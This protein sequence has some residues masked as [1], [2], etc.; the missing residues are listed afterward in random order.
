M[1][2]FFISCVSLAVA[3]LAALRP[4]TNLA[5]PPADSANTAARNADYIVAIVNSEPITNN[6]V[7]TRVLR[8][9]QQLSQRGGALPARQELMRQ[10]LD[11][12]IN[13]RTQVQLGRENGVR[14]EESALDGAVEGVA[15]QNQISVEQL[16]KELET[17][18]LS[19]AQ[20]RN[21]LRDE[22]MLTRVREREV[23]PRVRVTEA[24]LDAFV[25]EQQDSADPNAVELNI[26]QILIAVP[27]SASA[28]QVKALQARAERA[29]SRARAGDDF[30]KLAR[31]FSD[32]PDAASG[33]LLGLRSPERYPELFV[34]AVQTLPVGGIS[35]TVRSGAGFHILKLADKRQTGLPGLTVTQSRASHILLRITPQMSES[36]AR[37]RLTELRRRLIGGQIDFA[38][39]AR[40]NSQDGSGKDGGDLGW[41]NPG[42][43]VP[44][45]EEVMNSLAPGEVSQPLVSRF[46]VHLIAL[47]E[48]RNA[49]LDAKQQR[50]LARGALREKK[51]EEAFITWAQEVRGRAYVE[52]RE[53]PR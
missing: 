3:S 10:V 48:R 43:F 8:F 24:E 51:I 46:G 45:F 34:K 11:R 17:Q 25:K 20:F 6:E 4:S 47:Q 41:A 9:E 13:E 15:R 5:S 32:S 39:A 22:M 29:A 14:V 38:T 21:G 12:L 50:E 44:E 33:G 35:A 28:D 40:N 23:E 19:Y 36:A 2:K 31:E 1:S 30:T 53:P 52:M 7:R 42:Q 27:E 37:E 18:G 26:A 49:T 16:R